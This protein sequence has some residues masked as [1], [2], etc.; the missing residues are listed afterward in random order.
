MGM[1]EQMEQHKETLSVERLA[2]L[3]VTAGVDISTWGT[4]SAK[5]VAQLLKEMREGESQV[6]FHPET[7]VQRAVRVAWVDVLYL[8]GHGNIFQLVEDRQE[9][10]DG[11]LRKRQ[12]PSSLGEKFKLGE[13][14]DDAAI[15]ALN[16]ELGVASFKSLH[17]IGQEQELYTPDSYPG[18][19]TNYETYSFVAVLDDPSFDPDGYIEHQTDKINYYTWEK[20]HA[21][22]TES[23]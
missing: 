14:P 9:Y 8:D 2:G 5:T 18:L 22:A 15:R 21:V 1:P 3:L 20:I 7:G 19:A 4:G 23:S 11:R 17:K 16:E 12:L 13:N 6:T 10:R